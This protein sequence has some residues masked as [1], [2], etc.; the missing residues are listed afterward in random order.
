VPNDREETLK[1]A[2]KLLRQGRLDGAIAEYVRV[3]EEHPRDWATV[4]TLGDLYV[5]AGQPD[6]AAAQYARIAEHFMAEGFYPK[7]SATYKKLLKLTPDDEAS[8]LNLAEISQKQG[9][10]ADAKARLNAVAAKRRGRGDRAGAAEIVVLLGAL[11]PADFE[12]RHAG[13]RMLAEMGRDDEAAARFRGIYDDLIEKERPQEALA[14]LRQSVEL[15]PEDRE[16]RVVLAK[17]AVEAGDFETARSFLDRDTAGGDPV[18]QIALVEMDLKAGRLDAARELL[19][20]LLA[21]GADQRQQL[22]EIGW[23]FAGSN[24]EAAF[25]VIDAAVDA[26]AARREFGDA[27]ALL[28]EFVARVPRQIP[29]LLKLVEICVDGGLE[30]TMNETQAELADAYLATGQPTE[31]RV[32]AEDLVAREPW[33]RA[34]ID[35]FRRALVMLKVHDP[36][37]VIADRLSGHEPFIAKDVFADEPAPEPEPEAPAPPPPIAVSRLPEESAPAEAASLESPA[38]LVQPPAEPEPLD[39]TLRAPEPLAEAETETDLSDEPRPADPLAPGSSVSAGEP[40]SDTFADVFGA[41]A[42]AGEPGPPGEDPAAEQMALARTYL[43]MNMPDEA[44]APLKAAAKTTRHRFEAASTLGRLYMQRGETPNA[45]EWLERAA[46]APA[47][48]ADEG[49]S[50]RYDLGTLIED[51]GD[52]SRALAVFLE[53]QSEAGQYRDVAGK[54]ERLARVETG[55]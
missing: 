44:L 55:G 15:N 41:P 2:E 34:H 4:N 29:A 54:V 37:T 31:A 22:V 43:E 46:E 18:L 36:D 17:A 7:A 19:P 42:A 47:P 14:A 30:A 25:V 10:L 32:I 48:T 5:R 27:A 23:V 40:S 49:Y 13:A 20:A 8:Q 38:P 3:V 51:S 1:K 24:P 50:V 35:R 33:E 12:A 11:D 39:L 21:G 26:A 45:I 9:L 53:L 52:T 28:Q 16:G 6:K